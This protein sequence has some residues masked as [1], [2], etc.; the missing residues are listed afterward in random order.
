LEGSGDARP[1]LEG[2]ARELTPLAT[3]FHYPGDL[4]VP[5]EQEAEALLAQAERLVRHVLDAL[6]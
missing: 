5:T 4:A 1:E 6:A 2:A 3:A